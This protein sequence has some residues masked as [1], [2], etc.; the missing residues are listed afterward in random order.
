MHIWKCLKTVLIAMSA[1]LAMFF[2]VG[3]FAD[4]APVVPA[5]DRKAKLRCTCVENS[6]LC[7]FK[8]FDESAGKPRHIWTQDIFLRKGA[9]IDLSAVCF[10]KRNAEGY[11]DG[12]CCAV[13]PIDS[14][15]SNLRFF[16]G[17][18]LN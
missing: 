13:S 5:A 17:E 16:R 15:E 6:S 1:G 3:A 14:V 12:R 11:G 9:K 18:L 8:R 7:V 10:N 4:S 2:S